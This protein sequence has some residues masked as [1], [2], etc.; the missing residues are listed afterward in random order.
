M[1]FLIDKS[2]HQVQRKHRSPLVCGQ[3]VTPLTGYRNWGGVYAVD[4]GAFSSFRKDRFVRILNRDIARHKKCLFV[5][6]P[7]RVGDWQETRRL[8]DDMKHLIPGC[9]GVAYVAQDHQP[10]SEIPWDEISC[11]FVG[12]KD[13][14]KDSEHAQ[15]L[16]KSAK[17][18][19]KHTHIGRV[20][21]IE[22]FTL[23]DSLGADTC[24]G[25]GIARYDHMLH[26]IESKLGMRKTNFESPNPTRHLF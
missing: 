16:V 12:G 26:K 22:R 15:S 8:F 3:L 24:D 17:D 13:P 25:S 19:R 6:C 4:N 2:P 7:D 20:N 10:E 9:Y 5:V 1:R 11:L 14:W 21:E 18:R 23:F